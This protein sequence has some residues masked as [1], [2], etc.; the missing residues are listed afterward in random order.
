[1]A[2]VEHRTRL[3]LDTQHIDARPE[4]DAFALQLVH[5]RHG[6]AKRGLGALAQ[7][8]A[9]DKAYAQQHG[10]GAALASVLSHHP[11]YAARHHLSAML[12]HPASEPTGGTT[13]A[14]SSTSA[15]TV[16]VAAPIVSVATPLPT[17]T[18]APP[19]APTGSTP[20]ATDSQAVAVGGALDITIQ[21][22]GLAGADVTYIIN[23]QPLPQNMT[24][25]R[26]TGALTFAPAPG[27]AGAYQFRVTASNGTQTVVEPVSIAVSQ[28][29]L[30]STA[31]SGRVVDESGN[32]L[33]DL[34]VSIGENAATTDANGDFTLTGVP[35]N[36][37]PLSAGGAVASGLG[38]LGLMAPVDQLLGHAL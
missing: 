1:M 35:S 13:P 31:V 27:Q 15:S 17:P 22:G 14:S 20:V 23:P 28:P 21:P 37:S 29:P 12:A 34:P 38:R 32:P 16:S 5:N 11:A 9:N 36:P 7:M 30:A 10:W 18:P 4:L 33:V 19:A 3:R 26:G 24:F 2:S 25:N 8:I 6:A